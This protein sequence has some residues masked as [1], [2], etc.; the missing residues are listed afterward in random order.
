VASHSSCWCARVCQSGASFLLLCFV[1][2]C[3]SIYA[4]VYHRVIGWFSCCLCLSMRYRLCAMCTGWCV[5]SVLL[6]VFERGAIYVLAY[7]TV[8]G[9]SCCC[10]VCCYETTF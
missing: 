5:L 3:G 8:M 6:Y 9:R 2:A 10:V 1:S 4:L 7:L